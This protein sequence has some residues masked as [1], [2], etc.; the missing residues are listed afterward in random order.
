[1]RIPLI[2]ASLI[3]ALVLALPVG[4]FAQEAAEPSAPTLE[5][6]TEPAPPAEE[7]APVAASSEPAAQPSQSGTDEYSEGGVPTGT[8]ED[9]D[10]APVEE[11]PPAEDPAP[12]GSGGSA[13]TGSSAPAEASAETPV[14]TSE[15]TG[16]P[17]TGADT[18]PLALIGIALL[19][20][21]LLVR[22]REIATPRS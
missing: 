3:A 20:L 2:V 17:R 22:R 19:G 12:T 6:V 5:P 10:P 7:P 14:T 15:T 18:W 21:G 4:A 8:G 11:P 13:P 16:L 1:M 9:E